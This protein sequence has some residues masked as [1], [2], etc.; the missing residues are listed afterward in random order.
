Y[1]PAEVIGKNPRIL[2]SGKT[3]PEVYTELWEKISNGNEWRGEF[4]NRKK[5]GD[6]YW[7]SASISPI[8]D[9]NGAITHYVAIK[10]DITERKQMME[11]LKESEEKYHK[12]FNNEINAICIFD[13][14][15]KKFLDVNNAY[16][17]LYGYT[18]EEA[19]NLTADSV[20]AEQEETN[21]AI[22]KAKATE[23]IIVT[24]RKHRKKDGT[25]FQVD[26]SAGVY[27]WKGRSVMFAVLR[28]ITER[29][30]AEAA[31]SLSNE[32][33]NQKI[34]EIEKLHIALQEQAA[35]DP[36]TRLYNR[37]YM[38]EALT[39]EHARAS[40]KNEPLSVVM[41]D[42]DGLKK[43]ND[44]YGHDMGDQAI[45][46]F[47]NQLKLMARAE[48]IACRYGGDEFLVILYNT[49]IETAVQRVNG[50]HKKMEM[51][52]IPYQETK[53]HITFSA[54]IAAYPTHSKN[55]D[56]VVKMADDA[57]YQEKRRKA[58][59][60]ECPSRASAQK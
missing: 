3:L 59:S 50:W 31:L 58:Q 47:G 39:R 52:G 33:L 9:E 38:E 40:R 17:R 44:T 48:D 30:K 15:T 7:E 10:E 45:R 11:N 32:K 53:L 46:I 21:R 57:L 12:L 26:I 24:E 56:E 34:A 27:T 14:E 42:L 19:L 28:D 13:A 35:R 2:K 4:C 5:N 6:L 16:L 22:E 60:Q 55:I 8:M 23:G 25:V 29:K 41:I 20:S 1:S 36:L 51:V 54:G 49:D 43:F 37:R 18:R